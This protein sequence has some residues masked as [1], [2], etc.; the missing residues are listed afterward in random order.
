MNNNPPTAL[1]PPEHGDPWRQEASYFFPAGLSRC[2]NPAMPFPPEKPQNGR[3]GIRTHEPLSRLPIF[4]TGAFDH[5]A[6]RAVNMI[7]RLTHGLFGLAKINQTRPERPNHR[8]LIVGST[9]K[10]EYQNP[11]GLD[12]IANN[13]LLL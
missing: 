3:G 10:V 1:A 5:S 9:T 4:K 6:T 7:A 11:E 8:T 2:K 12:L 13:A